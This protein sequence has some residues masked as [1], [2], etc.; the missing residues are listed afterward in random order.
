MRSGLAPLGVS[1]WR[2]CSSLWR[3][4]SGQLTGDADD[5]GDDDG[6]DFLSNLMMGLGL[7]IMVLFVGSVRS[8]GIILNCVCYI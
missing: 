7:A 2:S 3:D 8:V 4:R 1:A 5:D 6:D